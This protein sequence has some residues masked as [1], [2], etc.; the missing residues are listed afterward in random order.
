MRSLALV[1]TLIGT[2]AASA[3]EAATCLDQRR[4]EPPEAACFELVVGE[5]VRT[6]RLFV[7]EN[8]RPAPAPLVLVLHGGGGSAAGMESASA[9]GFHREARRAGFVVAYPEGLGRNWNDGRP[10]APHDAARQD[11]DDVGFIAALIDAVGRR[12]AVDRNRIY[13]TGISNGGMMS[14]RLACELADRIAAVAAVAAQ[15]APALID[16]CRPAQ[17]VG[18]LIVNG[19]ADPIV[20]YAGGE[21]RI[22]GQSRGRVMGSVETFAAFAALMDCRRRNPGMR[23]G[24]ETAE[25]VSIETWAAAGCR[26]GVAVELISVI[27]GGHAW[28]SGV[29]YLPER[30]VGPVSRDVD[31][32]ELIWAFFERHRRS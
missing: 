4:G 29:Q 31:G 8:L 27:G 6:Y 18:V 19:T 5:T 17:P 21:V 16:R 25:S 3:A 15:P 12:H 9:R 11:R 1:L 7:P 28:P 2:V 32:A 13:A 26:G 24:R 14:Y 10:D 20:P 22:L 30:L 23:S